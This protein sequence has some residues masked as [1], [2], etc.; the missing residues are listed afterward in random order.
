M[1]KITQHNIAEVASDAVADVVSVMREL[2]KYLGSS[3]TRDLLMKL[4]DAT[5]NLARV[6]CVKPEAV[7][8]A[9]DFLMPAVEPEVAANVQAY[10]EHL[11]AKVAPLHAAVMYGATEV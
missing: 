11:C 9:V 8:G 1:K 5:G 2:E 4:L 6:V 10:T 7:K 3:T